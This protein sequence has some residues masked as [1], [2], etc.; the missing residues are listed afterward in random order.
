MPNP[1]NNLEYL[2]LADESFLESDASE[3]LEA[4]DTEDAFET[5]DEESLEKNGSEYLQLLSPQP[6]E[7]VYCEIKEILDTYKNYQLNG[8]GVR[9]Y[10]NRYY[11]EQYYYKKTSQKNF[12]ELID[13]LALMDSSGQWITLLIAELNTIHFDNFNN[14]NKAYFLDCFYLIF[15]S[16]QN[17][18]FQTRKSQN[19]K[20]INNLMNFYKIPQADSLWLERY[21][22]KIVYNGSHAE[23]TDFPPVTSE[24][25]EILL[26]KLTYDLKQIRDQ[27]EEEDSFFQ[28]QAKALKKAIHH[29]ADDWGLP[30]KIKKTKPTAEHPSIYYVKYDATFSN[31]SSEKAEKRKTQKITKKIASIGA[32][33][34]SIGEGFVAATGIIAVASFMPVVAVL[35]IVGVSGWYINRL[36]FKD[37]SEDVLNALF[38]KKEIDG[39][40][41]RLIFLKKDENGNY[42]PISKKK[43]AFISLIGTFSIFTGLV[44][45]ALNLMSSLAFLHSSNIILSALC[46]TSASFPAVALALAVSWIFFKVIADFIKNDRHKE[47]AQY[48]KKTF[49]D[50][51]W[52]EMS[53]K[54]RAAHV[55]KC[56]AKTV[57]CLAAVAVTTVVTVASFGVFYNSCLDVLR[58]VAN[59]NPMPYIAKAATWINGIISFPFQVQTTNK[60]VQSLFFRKRH[61][62]SK[63]IDV[64][65]NKPQLNALQ[66][67]ANKLKQIENTVALTTNIING[68]GQ[69]GVNATP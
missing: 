4:I 20:Y 46:L 37:D 17:Q 31:I 40:K 61:T 3:Y 13:R 23:L 18:Y 14:G 57:M 53:A 1:N 41:H 26:G 44:N 33:T 2:V 63:T 43:K 16:W 64:S 45:G 21:F 68:I 10:W 39:Q 60:V 36:L 30:S 27:I 35:G 67:E 51:P 47:I 19:E 62:F 48:V 34:S 7:E 32:F 58:K 59:A 50:V 49:L 8:A 15:H 65:T 52:K 5:E 55:G 25:D 9:G 12:V 54:E 24:G 56:V 66:K 42:Q 11:N 28:Q 22:D 29:V 69:A 6:H 38:I